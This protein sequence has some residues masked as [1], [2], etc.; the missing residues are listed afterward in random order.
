MMND[1]DF[2]FR[3]YYCKGDYI[4]FVN[5]NEFIGSKELLELR[6][7]TIYPRMMVGHLETSE[8]YTI[9][10]NDSEKVFRDKE[11]A[12]AYLKNMKVSTI[13]G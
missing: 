10:V 1:P 2:D 6:L 4:Y 9:G 13:Y 5:V 11:L 8:C 12:N 7:R 3:D